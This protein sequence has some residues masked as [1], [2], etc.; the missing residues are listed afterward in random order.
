MKKQKK[1]NKMGNK[2]ELYRKEGSLWRIRALKSDG[3]FREGELGGLIASERNLDQSGSCWVYVAAKVSGN[4]Q[5]TGNA[6]VY[7]GAQV[8]GDA[9]VTGNA[10]VYGNAQ[11]YGNA[12]VSGNAEVYGNAKV[13]GLAEV[14]GNAKVTDSHIGGTAKVG[15]TAKFV[16]ADGIVSGVYEKGRDMTRNSSRGEPEAVSR[17]AVVNAALKARKHRA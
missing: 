16:G 2:Y 1:E 7:G 14:Y 13:S 3:I 4:A 5:V 15:G 17:N 10:K 9:Q 6:E 12:R 8:Y 11:V